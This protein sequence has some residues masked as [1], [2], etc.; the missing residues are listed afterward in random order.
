MDAER[1][2][3]QLLSVIAHSR[4]TIFTADLKRRVT[5]LEGALIWDNDNQNSKNSEWFIGENVYTVFN[6][7]TEQ[8]AEGEKPDFLQPIEAVLNGQA[9][10][11]VGVD[12]HSFS[13]SPC[14]L[15]AATHHD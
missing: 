13:K 15:A 5:M 9:T 6:R 11:G 8:L 2:R 14:Y 7:L 1:T 4:V 3:K 12:E 10:D